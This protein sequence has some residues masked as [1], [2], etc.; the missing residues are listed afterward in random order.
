ME[1][2]FKGIVRLVG[3]GRICYNVFLGRREKLEEFDGVVGMVYL[4]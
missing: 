1:D 2:I 4:L 3:F